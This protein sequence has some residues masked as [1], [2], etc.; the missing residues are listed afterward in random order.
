MKGHTIHTAYW[1]LIAL[2]G[3][4]AILYLLRIA[5]DVYLYGR[6][7][8]AALLVCAGLALYG[9]LIAVL[10]FGWLI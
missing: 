1:F 4:A 7:G 6:A 3:L 9:G 5:C 2:F 8:L 10:F